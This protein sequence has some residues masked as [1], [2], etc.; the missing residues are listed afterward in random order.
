MTTY[1]TAQAAKLLGIGRATLH[2]WMLER[3]FPV[4]KLRKVAGVSVRFWTF[5]EIEKVGKYMA[6]H[7]Q[8]GKGVKK[9]SKA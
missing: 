7:Y 6:A 9:K 3:K 8:E 5:K 4:P 2:R 1:S